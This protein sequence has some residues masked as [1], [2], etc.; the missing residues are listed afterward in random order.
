MRWQ[1]KLAINWKKRAALLMA[2]AHEMN[3]TC[4]GT[5]A[6]RSEL[7][8]MVCSKGQG[9]HSIKPLR[10]KIQFADPLSMGFVGL[11]T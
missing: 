1:D 8:E 2:F 11:R 9:S 4:D 10:L 6:L 3:P 5:N 7:D